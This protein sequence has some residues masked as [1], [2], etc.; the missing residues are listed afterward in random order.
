MKKLLYIIPA[1][2][3]IPYMCAY[4]IAHVFRMKGRED[5]PTIKEWFSLED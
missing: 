1:F 5:V 4:I 2:L 3:F